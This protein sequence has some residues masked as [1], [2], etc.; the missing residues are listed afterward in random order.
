M[1]S[2]DQS[3]HDCADLFCQYYDELDDDVVRRDWLKWELDTSWQS[4]KLS[5]YNDVCFGCPVNRL[6][7]RVDSLNNRDRRLL[8]ALRGMD[9]A[10]RYVNPVMKGNERTPRG[11]VA[12][13]A[14][15]AA[16]GRL[17]CGTNGGA[18]IPRLVRRDDPT[19]DV[20]H[21]RDLLTYVQRVPQE[22][23]ERCNVRFLGAAVSLEH[24]DI[25]NGF[26]VA[27]VPVIADPDELHFEIRTM[28]DRRFYRIR[29]RDLAVTRDRI[30]AIV[31]ALDRSGAMIAVAP[32]AMLTPALLKCWQDSLRGRSGSRLRWL[33]AGTGDLKPT[34]PPA[35]NRAVLLDGRTGAVIGEQDKLFPFNLSNETLKSRNLAS[36]LG[37]KAAG[38]DLT[39]VPTRLT[40][41]DAG[42]VRL[43]ILICEDLN[44]PL[45]TGPLIRDLGISHLLVP[46]FSR[47]LQKHRWEQA[48]ASVHVRET[49]TTVIV[50]NSSVMA[51][52]LGIATPGTSLVVTPNSS[53]AAVGYSTDPAVPACFR[54]LP[55]GSAELR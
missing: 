39:K 38:E 28:G 9:E 32:E 42:A 29:P 49:G 20:N 46:V 18:L 24:S 1:S 12:L 17:D 16:R 54:L 21:K 36:R 47:A 37:G 22:S 45:D 4:L 23:W 6:S 55:D 26:D 8:A 51:T 10:F 52:I 30:P 53:G 50:S 19:D 34:V 14:Y 27:C 25:Q 7:T 31:A 5:F 3:L 2:V 48:A 11:L 44:K 35:A 41:F 43:A 15:V 13:E 40:V 33:L